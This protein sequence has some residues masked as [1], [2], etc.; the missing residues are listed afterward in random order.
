MKARTTFRWFRNLS[1]LVTLI[2]LL[3]AAVPL[4]AQVDSGSILG[5][6]TDESGAVVSGASVTLTN[7][8]TAASLTTMT[9]SD[10]SYKFTPVKIGS[11]KLDSLAQG[12]PA[13]HRKGRRRQY[14]CGRGSEFRTETRQRHSVH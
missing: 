6:I 1:P 9:G 8:G 10:G 4:R 2:A 3:L 14:R 7:E 12:I 11:Y 5:T 13:D